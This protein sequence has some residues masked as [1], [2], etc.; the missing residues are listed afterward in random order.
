[1]H[2]N[3]CWKIEIRQV[4]VADLLKEVQTS[5]LGLVAGYSDSVLS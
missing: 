3:D 4:D 2:E 5:N 1:M